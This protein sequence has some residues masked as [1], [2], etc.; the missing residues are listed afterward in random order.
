M[1]KR[2]KKTDLT[3]QEVKRA[4]DGTL[5]DIAF[6]SKRIAALEAEAEQSVQVIMSNYA[7]MIEPLRVQLSRDIAWLKDTMK[8]NKADLFDGMDVVNL[9]HGSLIRELADKVSLSK[10]SLSLCEKN[11][12]LDA[13]KIAKSL[14]RSVV[15]KWPD[16]KLLLI[17]GQRKPKEEFSYELKKEPAV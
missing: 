2:R 9:P 15:E 10:D 14:D 17:N 6:T 8:S 11:G 16:A 12:F 4:A 5:A 7:E 3:V 13:I 1:A